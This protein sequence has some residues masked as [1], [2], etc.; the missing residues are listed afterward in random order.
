[1][2]RVLI[3]EDDPMVA[4][5]NRSYI[6]RTDDF[7]CVGVAHSPK[8]ARSFLAND[9]IDLVLLDVYMPGQDGLS[10]LQELRE[11][12]ASVDV[13]LITAASET[14]QIQQALRLGAIDY[15]IKPYAFDRLHTALEKFKHHHTFIKSSGQSSQQDIDALLHTE[16]HQESTQILVPKGLTKTTLDHVLDVI[17]TFGGRRFSTDEVAEAASLSR[18]S[19]RKYLK[20][21]ASHL[22]LDEQLEYGVGRPVYYYK[23]TAKP[24][25]N[26]QFSI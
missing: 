17:K 7:S 11:E 19:I 8:E 16:A 1:M 20:F 22:F 18:V 4:E 14:K 13:I 15:L 5:L 23:R 21:L 3:V 9:Q 26:D 2:I 10:Y 24:M 25:K 12:R 6:E